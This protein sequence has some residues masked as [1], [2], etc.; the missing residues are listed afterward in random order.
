MARGKDKLT[1]YKKMS[2]LFYKTCRCAILPS[3]HEGMTNVMLEA[4][5]MGRPVITTQVPRCQET[6]P[7][8][9]LPIFR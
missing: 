8:R 4:S 6:F 1:E 2:D 7:R 3:Y 5:S 9:G